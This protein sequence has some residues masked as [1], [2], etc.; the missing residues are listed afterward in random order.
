MGKIRGVYDFRLWRESFVKIGDGTTC[1]GARVVCDNSRVLIGSDCLFSD[2]II[3][4]SADQHG[5]VDTRT[6]KF[7]NAEMTNIRIGN[8]VWVGRRANI[9]HGA[10]IGDG[11]IV[12]FGSLVNKK[13]PGNTLVV[14]VPGVVKKTD[15]TWSRNT[16]D[17]DDYC[18][19]VIT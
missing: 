1:N 4:Q 10:D 2:E 13:I 9:L 3:V 19:G 17:L 16:T 6:K 8:H 5:L 12:G 18:K 11:A 15:I 14:G 7:L